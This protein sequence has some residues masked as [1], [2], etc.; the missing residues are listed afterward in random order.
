MIKSKYTQ[1]STYQIN[2]QTLRNEVHKACDLG[3][4]LVNDICFSKHCRH[5]LR[6]ANFRIYNLFKAL[7]YSVFGVQHTAFKA[8]V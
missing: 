2:G 4:I 7:K 8:Y 5:F 1:A 6:N 3:F